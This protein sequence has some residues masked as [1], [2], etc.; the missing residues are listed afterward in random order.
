MLF[1]VWRLTKEDRAR[2]NLGIGETRIIGT[3]QHRC[4]LSSYL[5][6]DRL[7]TVYTVNVGTINVSVKSGTA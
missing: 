6:H 5:L 3:V 2:H 1:T 4:N 7:S